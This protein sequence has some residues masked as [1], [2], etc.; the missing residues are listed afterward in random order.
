MFPL[1]LILV[2]FAADRL[3]KRWAFSF[4]S[5]HG[6]TQINAYL[7]IQETYNKGIAFGMFQG[8]GPYIGWLT[9]VVVIGMFIY[10][11][12]L[13]KSEKLT[14]I[15]LALIIGGALGN[16]VDRVMT[17][18]VLDFIVT[19][20]RSSV[21]NVADIAINVGMAITILATVLSVQRARKQD[22]AKA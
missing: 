22:L 9:I 14:R 7:S 12:R 3:S 21:F 19:P 6:P 13:P 11:L 10:L 2:V 5:E 1:F 17:G 15:G 18:E 8:A 16:M 20:L 4:L